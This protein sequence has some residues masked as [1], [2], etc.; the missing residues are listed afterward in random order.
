MEGKVHLAVVLDDDPGRDLGQARQ[1]GHRFFFSP[2]EVEP[3]TGDAQVTLA[4]VRILIAGIGNI[5]LAD[6]AFG[7]EVT[8]RL[9]D[10]PQPP[11]V[12]VTDFGIRGMDLV[13]ALGEGYDA[14]VFVDA[15][16]RG[17]PPGTLFVIEPDL[18]ATEGAGE[19]T[20]DAHGMDPV[21]VLALAAQLGPIPDRVLVVGCEPQVQMTGEEEDL[22]GELS[23]PVAAAVE[24]GVEMVESVIGEL[25]EAKA[26]EAGG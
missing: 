4:P 2:A 15:V 16:P 3:L 22:V 1:P 9:L 14:V 11:G 24:G 26:K 12:E 19:I 21:R 20:L 10:R 8:K 5:F 7:I 18:E 23:P 25:L 17:E 6:D 13:Y